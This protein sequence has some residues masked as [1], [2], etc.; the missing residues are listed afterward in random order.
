MKKKDKFSNVRERNI[1]ISKLVWKGGGSTKQM[2]RADSQ[3]KRNKKYIKNGVKSQ[4]STDLFLDCLI[5]F[6]PIKSRMST[7]LHRKMQFQIL[8]SFHC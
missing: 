4:T 3:M 6:W 2:T 7:R 5:T 1:N 8:N